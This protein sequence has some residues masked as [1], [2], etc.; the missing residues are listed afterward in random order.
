M[1][2]ALPPRAFPPSRRHYRLSDPGGQPR[3]SQP[4]QRGENTGGSGPAPATAAAD[5]P[6]QRRQ[7]HRAAPDLPPAT[8]ASTGNTGRLRTRAG[9]REAPNPGNAGRT[10]A[11]LGPR[12]RRS[13]HGRMGVTD[14]RR[15]APA[16]PAA[17]DPHRHW[18]Q[19]NRPLWQRGSRIER[20]QGRPRRSRQP[21]APTPATTTATPAARVLAAANGN[22]GSASHGSS[23]GR[24]GHGAAGN[25][26]PRHRQQRRR[27][28]RL[29]SW[30]QRTATPGVRVTDRAPAGPATAQ[31]G[32]RGP[33]TGNDGGDTSGSS[34][35][36]ANGN[37]GGGAGHG[38]S[39]GHGSSGCQ[40][41]WPKLGVGLRCKRLISIRDRSRRRSRASLYA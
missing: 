39:A 16:T 35:G 10:P 24:A 28:Q 25:Q 29:G 40:Q 1:L 3:G 2:G 27:H 14:Q 30:R 31:P 17:P 41:H 4:R 32:A 37:G 26:P 11:A 8:A 19:R 15:A 20:R 12:Q 13:R 23:A 21:A 5:R 6:R 33:D 38:G 36:A 7:Q 22:G 34:P 18:R 9:N